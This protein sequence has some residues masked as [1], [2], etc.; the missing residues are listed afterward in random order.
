MAT[1]RILSLLLA[2]SLI[3]ACS[4][5]PKAAAD[6]PENW[7]AAKFYAEAS[8]AMKDGDYE[9]AIEYYE[10]LEARY[11]FGRYATQSQLDVAYVY[12]KYDEPDSAIAALDR[13]IKLHPRNPHVDY[14]Y[15][16]KGIVNFNRSLGFI[17]RFMPTDISQRDAGAAMDS[18]DDFSELVR[19]FPDS[20]YA[21]DARKRL[22][23]LRNNLARH[24]IHVA[25]YYLDR[26]AYVA[27][28]NRCV[29]VVENYQ[30][31]PAVRD[32]L[33]I[34]IEAYDKLGLDELSA[35]AKRVL[36]LNEAKGSFDY[37]KGDG[38]D[39]PLG[40]KVWEFLELDKN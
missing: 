8:K 14:A 4:L 20:K 21:E 13:F 18:F 31:T 30:R 34:M 24:E 38:H 6:K 2:I 3:P 26:G 37:L 35:D 19:K 9:K 7:S 33:K 11:P 5:L 36:A 39:K 17:E 40:E 23:Y 27:A 32:A 15:Y 10:K 22:I 28:A 25:R 16:L 1:I 12:Y 29:Y